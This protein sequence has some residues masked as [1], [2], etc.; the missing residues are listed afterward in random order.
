MNRPIRTLTALALSGL[1]TARDTIT[2]HP[3]DLLLPPGQRPVR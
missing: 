1:L 3:G 2:Q